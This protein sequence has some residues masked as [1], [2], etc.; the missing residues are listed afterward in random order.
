LPKLLLDKIS[1]F[2]VD[3]IKKTLSKLPWEMREEYLNDGLKEQIVEVL[4]QDKELNIFFSKLKQGISD[5][6]S[7]A[8]AANYLTSDVLGL[9]SKS[10][11]VGKS[12]TEMNVDEFLALIVMVSDGVVSSRGAKDILAVW[13]NEGGDPND[14]AKKIGVLQISDSSELESIISD[15]LEEQASVVEEYK[16]G[17]ESV[18]QFLIGQ[19]MKVTKGAANPEMLKKIILDSIQK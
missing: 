10:Q 2:D 6:V 3:E 17:K 4:I 1:E 16:S 5:K 7:I 15:I 18:L 13:V 11:Y 12:I 14:I 8:L 19:G 9:M